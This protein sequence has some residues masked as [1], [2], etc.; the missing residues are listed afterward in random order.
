MLRGRLY[1]PI[2]QLAVGQLAWQTNY[3]RYV[4]YWKSGKNWPAGCRQL[5]L[6]FVDGS[7]LLLNVH[8]VRLW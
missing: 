5:I 6:T 7:E 1:V 8:I 3:E 2:R 4:Y